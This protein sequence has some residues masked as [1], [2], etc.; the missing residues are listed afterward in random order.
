MHEHTDKAF[1]G[2]IPQIY[3][4]YLVP[5]IFQPYAEELIAAGEGHIWYAAAARVLPRRG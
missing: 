3:Q 4:Q 5:L 2:S 1:S